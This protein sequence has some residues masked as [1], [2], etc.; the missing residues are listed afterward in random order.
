MNLVKHAFESSCHFKSTN[1]VVLCHSGLIGKKNLNKY[2]PKGFDVRE[3][4]VLA[5]TGCLILYL[6]QTKNPK[7]CVEIEN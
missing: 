5:V 1:E 2:S 3:L 7:W 6:N 4:K